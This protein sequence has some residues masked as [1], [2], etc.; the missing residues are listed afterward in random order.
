MV[1]AVFVNDVSVVLVTEAA[2]VFGVVLLV[3][4]LDDSVLVVYN[5]V[6]SVAVVATVGVHA[7]GIRAVVSGFV[8]SERAFVD[9]T[10]T[11]VVAEVVFILAAVVVAAVVVADVSAIDVAG[12]T[13][14]VTV[15]AFPDPGVFVLV[16]GNSVGVDV[17]A[18]NADDGVV[19]VDGIAAALVAASVSE[20]V[21]RFAFISLVGVVATA[22]VF[23]AVPVPAAYSV[24]DAITRDVLV[25]VGNV[26][27]DAD[28]DG[29][30]IESD[31]VIEPLSPDP[32]S[33]STLSVVES[34]AFEVGFDEAVVGVVVVVVVGNVVE[35]DGVASAAADAIVDDANVVALVMVRVLVI[36]VVVMAAVVASSGVTCTVGLIATSEQQRTPS[37]DGTGW[38]R[39]LFPLPPLAATKP[40]P[41]EHGVLVQTNF[42]SSPHPV[43]LVT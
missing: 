18:S 3:V 37:N 22:A 25:T 38:H 26:N 41:P 39:A 40:P 9:A 27:V 17:A 14:G 13:A 1:A 8:A 19:V 11:I 12:T 2:V 42:P 15:E 10:V 5:M 34:S 21:V 35:I 24:V 36:G 30:R 16:A 4:V 31:S 6:V 43:S 23:T 33:S 20:R 29:A 28:F 32:E 7:V